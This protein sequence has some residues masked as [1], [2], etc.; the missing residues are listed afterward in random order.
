[1]RTICIEVPRL[2]KLFHNVGIS[3]APADAIMTG[4]S[5]AGCGV[6]FFAAH[7]SINSPLQCWVLDGEW[8]RFQNVAS[9]ALTLR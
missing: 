1:L 9:L 7:A 2:G 6:H 3:E 4:I 5:A 8:R